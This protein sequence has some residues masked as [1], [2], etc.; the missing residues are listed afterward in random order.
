[1]R[2][3]A[4]ILIGIN[5]GHPNGKSSARNDY[6]FS[7]NRKCLILC[8]EF[9][10]FSIT[11]DGF[12]LSSILR[13]KCLFFLNFLNLCTCLLFV[14]FIN[15]LIFFLF[16]VYLLFSLLPLYLLFFSHFFLYSLRSLHIILLWLEWGRRNYPREA[17]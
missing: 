4:L 8:D 9:C 17:L 10:T 7:G 1:M 14:F 11:C 12:Q 6:A 3:S 15:Q 5:H 2:T 13:L 16:L